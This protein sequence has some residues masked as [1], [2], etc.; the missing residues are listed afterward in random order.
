MSDGDAF[1]RILCSLHKAALD[2]SHWSTASAL[3]EEALGAKGNALVFGDGRSYDD[4]RIFLARF[5]YRGE[6]RRELEREYFDVYYPLDE[7]VPRLR[8]LPDS[9]LVHATELYTEEERKNSVVYNEMMSRALSQNGV[10]VRLDGP[11]GSRIIWSIADPVD[12]SGWSSGRMAMIQRFLPH[13]RHYVAVRH[14]LVESGALGASM[15]GLLDR[16]GTGIIQLDEQGRVVAANDRARDL[17]R[18]GDGLSDEDGYLRVRSPDADTGLQRLLARALPRFNG[19]G[20][21]GSMAVRR[22]SNRPRLALHVVP[23]GGGE[24]D[25]RPSRVAALVLVVERH[26]GT[27]IDPA[28]LEAKLGLTPMESRVAALLAEGR[29]VHDIVAMTGRRENTIRWHVKHIYEKHGISRQVDLVR[30]VL[31]VVGPPGG[32]ASDR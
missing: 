8:Q 27:R 18:E 20:A 4:V 14:A 6:R 13:L 29:S 15:T 25:F 10:T 24:P 5:L 7:R 32:E 30:L 31:S 19:R 2:D 26:V 16:T 11:D 3:M 28:L 9:Q 17:L 12:G 23:V 1:D 22:S 21:G